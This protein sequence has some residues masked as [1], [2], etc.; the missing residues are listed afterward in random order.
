MIRFFDIEWWDEIFQSIGRNKRR[1]ILTSIGVAWG[2]FLLVLLLGVGI[3][4]SN[5]IIGEMKNQVSN[6]IFLYSNQTSIPYKGMK[7]GRRWNMRYSDLEEIKNISGVQ[8]VGSLGP[9]REMKLICD[10]IAYDSYL[11]AYDIGLQE[12]D[13]VK[14]NEGRLFNNIDLK[15]RRK[16]CMIPKSM[17]K[18][19]GGDSS[20]IGKTIKLGKIYFTII[21]TYIRTNQM[22]N[23]TNPD[24]TIIIPYTTDN[25]LFSNGTP[26]VNMLAITG[27]D[28]ADI[29][30]IEDCC[31]EILSRN[32]LVS[33]DDDKAI[34]SFN[35]KEL[36]DKIKGLFS[37][38]I[39]LTWFVGVGTLGAGIIGITNIMLIIVRERRVELGIRRALGA[40]PKE[41]VVQILVESSI[42]SLIAGIFGLIMAVFVQGLMDKI[43]FPTILQNTSMEDTAC[44]YTLQL[45]FN[46]AMLAFGLIL[47]GSCVAG[48][49]PAYKAITTSVVDALREE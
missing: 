29:A 10:D 25:Y 47:V 27:K 36:L 13:G 45:P 18:R 41:I 19:I 17:A 23:M 9:T 14:V 35:A 20:V 2:T 7:S 38:I 49:L 48:V 28:N 4:L 22:L 37:G 40:K 3:G 16:V 30:I 1:S 31:R 33:P 24:K 42:L 11:V 21:G 6:T 8:I 44:I 26:Y 39:L 43:F 15:E 34:I 32:H 46:M 5:I 12:I